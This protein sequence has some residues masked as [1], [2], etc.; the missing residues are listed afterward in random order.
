MAASYII[1]YAIFGFVICNNIHRII[2]NVFTFTNSVLHMTRIYFHLIILMYRKSKDTSFS[3]RWKKKKKMLLF[4]F[5]TLQ[6]NY[7]VVKKK[8]INKN[9]LDGFR[10]G[11]KC[12]IHY[13]ST[14]NRRF[15]I[16]FLYR[17]TKCP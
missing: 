17:K 6:F 16:R 15:L 7:F 9:V 14:Q 11:E 10:F 12:L 8:Y 2:Y 4:L 1:Y 5:F 3:N 13:S